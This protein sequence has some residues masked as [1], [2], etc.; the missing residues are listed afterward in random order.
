MKVVNLNCPNCGATLQVDGD[1]RNLKCE[2][3]G[4]ALFLDDEV[5]HVKI[6][7]PEQVGYDFEK[8][9]QRAQ[10]EHRL[11]IKNKIETSNNNKS[12]NINVRAM[13]VIAIM[14]A[15]GAVLMA[16]EFPIPMLIPPFIK[17][18]FSEVPALI[19]TFA[20]GPVPGMA[21]CLL[22]NLIHLPFGSSMGIGELANFIFGAVFT[23]VAGLIYKHRHNRKWAAISCAVGALAMS[24]VCVFVNYWLIYPLYSKVL[25]LSTE[26]IVGMYSQ[27]H[28]VNGLMAAL[29]LFNLPFTF[30]KGV[31]DS[32]IC[33]LIYKPLSPI[34]KGT[35]AAQKRS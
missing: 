6:E 9:R 31:I 2:Y 22:K 3:C 34:L 13:C 24:V 1:S 23:G 10:A 28:E 19:T 7:N 16:V 35:K 14:S 32:V 8:G 17:L 30:I 18:D 29:A 11:K 26:A 33:F 5:N 25:G 15:L 12:K 20:L 4:N 21:V 27:I